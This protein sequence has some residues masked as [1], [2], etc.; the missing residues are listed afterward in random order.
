MQ[1][2]GFNEVEIRGR[3]DILL[4]S[5]E[6]IQIPVEIYW[7]GTDDT[8]P[9]Q[10]VFL[11]LGDKVLEERLVQSGTTVTEFTNQPAYDIDGNLIPYTIAADTVD[12]Y[13]TSVEGYQII[14]QYIPKEEPIEEVAEQTVEPLQEETVTAEE[15]TSQ[16]EEIIPAETTT[17]EEQPEEQITELSEGS[18]VIDEGTITNEAAP[19][20]MTPLEE[21]ATHDLTTEKDASQ[22]NE[23]LMPIPF[24]EEAAP[25]E[26]SLEEST[27][28][29]AAMEVN[30]EKLEELILQENEE[31]NVLITAVEEKE[32]EKLPP[33]EEVNLNEYI[34]T[35]EVQKEETLPE[36]SPLTAALIDEGIIETKEADL[37]AI[38][39]LLIK[40]TS[41]ISEEII[42]TGLLPQ[43]LEEYQASISSVQFTIMTEDH[44][45]NPIE[46]ATY[47]LRNK[48]DPTI[49]YK[50]GASDSQ[51]I[52]TEE[53]QSGTYEIAQLNTGSDYILS[54]SLKEVT[55]LEENSSITVVNEKNEKSKVYITAVNSEMESLSGGEYLLTNTLDPSIQKTA[56][57]ATT[58]G[59][60]A[61]VPMGTY[62]ITETTAPTG[63][64][65]AEE[66][67]ILVVNEAKE[68]IVV[69]N[70]VE[71]LSTLTTETTT[72]DP[73]LELMGM[74]TPVFRS[75]MTTMAEGTM[76]LAA[77]TQSY[78]GNLVYFGSGHFY[79]VTAVQ[80]GD[81]VDWTIRFGENFGSNS[82]RMATDF[83][84]PD[85]HSLQGSINYWIRDYQYSRD[86]VSE[87]ITNVEGKSYTVQSASNMSTIGS[88]EL[89]IEF[90][91]IRTDNTLEAGTLNFTNRIGSQSTTGSLTVN[92]PV[93][94]GTLNINLTDGTNPLNGTFSVTDAAGK[95]INLTT[96]NGTVSQVLPT[97]TYTIRQTNTI[98]DGYKPDPN[99]VRTITITE[100]GTVTVNYINQSVVYAPIA[101]NLKDQANNGP[102]QGALFYLY[103]AQNNQIAS[104]TTDANGN[105]TFTST[106]GG[107]ETGKAYTIRQSTY[108]GKYI[109]DNP[110]NGVYSI[111]S[112]PEAGITAN[113]TN[114]LSGVHI[115]VN[116]KNP[117][118]SAYNLLA[119]QT[120][121][122]RLV[123]NFN[124]IIETKT[125]TGPLNPA[126]TTF[127]NMKPGNYNVMMFSISDGSKLPANPVPVTV[128]A[129][130]A[131]PS[132]VDLILRNNNENDIT[133]RFVD[134]NGNSINLAG[135]LF[136][137]STRDV[138]NYQQYIFDANGSDILST[139][140]N[141]TYNTANLQTPLKV[142]ET[143]EI[144]AFTI[145]NAASAEYHLFETF[146]YTVKGETNETVTITLVKKSPDT[147]AG[148]RVHVNLYEA[149]T[150]GASLEGGR[151][152]LESTGT[153]DGN[154]NMSYIGTTD[155]NG[156]I[157]F[158]SLPPGTY[159]LKQ[160]AAP[161]GYLL[162]PSVKT[163][164]IP[165]SDGTTITHNFYDQPVSPT[166]QSVLP[167]ID[168][169]YSY[170]GSG[171]D[172]GTYPVPYHQTDGT[173]DANELYRNRNN[174][175]DGRTPTSDYTVPAYSTYR[176][177]DPN[178][179]TADHDVIEDDKAYLWKYAT[180]TGTPGENFIDLVVE[181]KKHEPP[182]SKD[183]IL[184]LDNSASMAT[185][186][187][188]VQRITKL[189]AAVTQFIENVDFETANVN[190][191][192]VN[193]ATDI[194]NDV[195]LTNNDTEL[196]SK[197]PTQ[198]QDG[199]YGGPGGTFTQKAL[200][201]AEELLRDSNAQEKVI[202]L[203][204]D[205]APTFS[206]VIN[207][208]GTSTDNTITVDYGNVS[209]IDG[210]K[211]VIG[212][213]QSNYLYSS[214]TYTAEYPQD[215]ESSY[216]TL[217]DGLTV[218][219]ITEHNTATVSE[220]MSI[221]NLG[222]D[223]YAI[224]VELEVDPDSPANTLYYPDTTA[225]NG[226]QYV[227]K[228]EA[229]ANL[230]K[231]SSGEDYYFDVDNAD[232]LSAALMSL[233]PTDN[234]IIN[235]KVTDP[236]GSQIILSN[237]NNFSQTT[238][239]DINL[240]NG[241]YFLEASDPNLLYNQ[242]VPI[243]PTLDPAT[244]TITIDGLNLGY[245]EWVRIRYRINLRTEDPAFEE[246]FY[247]TNSEDTLLQPVRTETETYPFGVPAIKLPLVDIKITKIWEG[248]NP[249]PASATFEIQRR[250][251]GG[252][253]ETVPDHGNITLDAAGNWTAT[254]SDLI[255]Y[256]N[257]G[258][259][260]EY[261]VVETT[262]GEY[263]QEMT[264]QVIEGTDEYTFTNRA[265]KGSFI[266][267]KVDE[268]HMP[269][270][271]EAQFE[272]Y[273]DPGY[274]NKVVGPVNVDENG[275]F[276]FTNLDTGTY[277]LREITAPSGYIPEMEHIIVHVNGEEVTFETTVNNA[278]WSF[279]NGTVSAEGEV[280][281]IG[282]V[283][284]INR[285]V[286]SKLNLYKVD[287]DGNAIPQEGITFNIYSADQ[288]TTDPISG[289]ITITPEEIANP[290]DTL[291]TGP[292]GIAMGIVDLVPGNYAIVEDLTTA[293]E[294]YLG[295]LTPIEVT[296]ELTGD[297]TQWTI[298]ER[299]ANFATIRE[300]ASNP[301]LQLGINIINRRVEYPAT[302]GVGSM[303]FAVAGMFLMGMAIITDRKK[304]LSKE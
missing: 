112:L 226:S 213:G 101:V 141:G 84:I 270:P 148:S 85:G 231:I 27:M 241:D 146:K 95:V 5:R 68:G 66:I 142:G 164:I 250:L 143:Y 50:I 67:P 278:N 294:G 159:T 154:A 24:K 248:F 182:P 111:T 179:I 52:I 268:T 230:K 135:I 93:P 139:T 221:K 239:Q 168:P 280:L 252:I 136:S 196:L 260:F 273:S 10:K 22:N 149:V 81:I 147:S 267:N 211:S 285:K 155:A 266:L 37:S 184:V 192:M 103:D 169:M 247:L 19:T 82:L 212:T 33:L 69:E 126:A 225:V 59:A 287:G 283:T 150:P 89:W 174:V 214:T 234:T 265:K 18:S 286:T 23:I 183:I 300:E 104:G 121:V 108:P 269:I 20:V 162:D 29:T 166:I 160:V 61:E 199:Y 302:G 276:V 299:Y 130:S 173:G 120:I 293:P 8:P 229:E 209:K 65:P 71:P 181:G 25:I 272:L 9:D 290:K 49:V 145:G 172:S 235:G 76:S 109:A 170:S 75:L 255:K 14:N 54:S 40:D 257:E 288:Y 156:E 41:S 187:D 207:N 165:S 53:V 291:V 157:Y 202:I 132:P 34:L 79:K 282:E 12:Q 4:Q 127:E 281:N 246:K 114:K 222:I 21:T 99:P 57:P 77:T 301:G 1:L 261:Q 30:K 180:P 38:E 31:K 46:G 161:D 292:D 138:D 219:E 206:Y 158:N 237:N 78:G 256:N 295:L 3:E 43:A 151:F 86:R 227:V 193:Y 80:N 190:I 88:V 238:P 200:M 107:F 91:T 74:D 217:S 26:S 188:G 122:L 63:Y 55:V 115:P 44:L 134:E 15:Q 28:E 259:E 258:Q 39:P 244:N 218:E 304:L 215:S 73:A 296:L 60:V 228:S 263:Y 48:E 208:I 105:I 6:K 204:S 236:M 153:A 117:D 198:A 189:N 83:I 194:I 58:E 113:F 167:T 11:K 97:G 297:T 210:S 102:I 144:S 64:A 47:E 72:E 2:I 96:L 224:G 87:L 45:G 203:V 289:V 264:H 197:V 163:V 178:D 186:S 100:N 70:S 232:K 277:Y 262:T 195:P 171:V 284:L 32:A 124:N 94:K 92:Y 90:Q 7:N 56:G 51:G 233:I 275:Q 62:I 245:H 152:L 16:P 131:T 13:T 249:E 128:T 110:A 129:T 223:I 17:T 140:A 177:Y 175:L 303:F 185:A 216:T 137:I 42:E 279:V 191:G 253:W 254:I 242:G 116:I 98:P 119:G 201:R 123:D 106:N 35:G 125:I 243:V 271:M 205:G 133:I 176:G 274:Q 118:G 240:T 251:A 36:I 298:S 220:A